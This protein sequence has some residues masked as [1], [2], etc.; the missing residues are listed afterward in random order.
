VG[1]SARVGRDGAGT[2]RLSFTMM[3][4]VSELG[5][6]VASEM[7]VERRSVR[8]WTDPEGKT[9]V[10]LRVP[11]DDR[12]EAPELLRELSAVVE[13]LV[14]DPSQVVVGVGP[15]ASVHIPGK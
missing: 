12:A 3:G 13:G 6:R 10:D 7:G 15:V 1:P 9:R 11:E 4:A 5:D 14:D 2:D 8:V